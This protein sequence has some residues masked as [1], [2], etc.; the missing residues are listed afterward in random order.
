MKNPKKIDQTE[1]NEAIFLT[2][3]QIVEWLESHRAMMFEVW[4]SNPKLR[5][6]WEF[7]NSDN[8]KK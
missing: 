1:T 8:G 7:L 6:Q 2:P 3:E 5:E 4:K